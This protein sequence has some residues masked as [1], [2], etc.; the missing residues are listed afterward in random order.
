MKQLRIFFAVSLLAVLLALCGG[1]RRTD[2]IPEGVPEYTAVS[3]THLT[4]P[5]KA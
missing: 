5:T 4:L 1:C 3:Y 2:E